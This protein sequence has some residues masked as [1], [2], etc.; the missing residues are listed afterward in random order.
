MRE[1]KKPGYNPKRVE[2]NNVRRELWNAKYPSDGKVTGH[3]SER[4]RIING[5]AYDEFDDP[6]YNVDSN[7]DAFDH[8]QE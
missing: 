8:G 6:V 2:E 4:Y 1:K 3:T 5:V 7:E